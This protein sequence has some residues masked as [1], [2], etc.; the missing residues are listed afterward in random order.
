MAAETKAEKM[1]RE[2]D[3][4]DILADIPRFAREGVKSISE[5]DLLRLRWYGLYQQRPN[6]GH[7]MVRIKIPGGQLNPA[8]TRVIADLARRFGH[9]LSDIT[10]RQDIQLHWV[11]IENFPTIMAELDQ[12]G[13]Y[14]NEACGD[15][16]RNLVAC[17]LSGQMKDELFD[18]A[19]LPAIISRMYKDG[20][21]E[22]SN[23]PRK[24]KMSLSACPSHCTIPQIHCLS[25]FGVK[26]TK[27][28]REERG[29]GVC[30]GGG[31]RDTPHYAQSLRVFVPYEPH[32]SDHERVI[33]D[34]YR[35]V[36]HLFRDTDSLRQNRMRARLKFHVAEIGWEK[37]R[38]KL[39][40]NLGYKLEH[41]ESITAPV[42]A[43]LHD[44]LGVGELKNGLV[45]VGIPVPRGR[46]S[47]EVLH[48]LGDL[49]EK[50]G[51]D[52]KGLVR[53]TA[54]QNAILLNIPRQNLNELVQELT[55]I[56]LDPHAS[57]LRS[58]LIS[59]TGIQFCN[60]AITETKQRAA[61]I[62]AYLEHRLPP[63]EHVSIH[64][65]GCPN[66]CA[67]YQIADIGMSGLLMTWKGRPRQDAFSVMVGGQLGEKAA[68]GRV[69][70]H[71]DGKKLKLPSA[72]AHL[73]IEQL[74]L[75]YLAGRTSKA[76]TFGDFM[77]RHDMAAIH[78]WLTTPAMR[79][80]AA[81]VASVSG[82]EE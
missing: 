21:K 77:D 61:D 12:V 14:L 80:E 11:T 39:E 19:H 35:Q 53:L 41:D 54:K 2:K 20:G 55:Q 40:E 51:A 15:T 1:K 17:P 46:L 65:S 49:A 45:Y 82:K 48:T 37:F 30:V 78:N 32:N 24:F 43:T 23:L 25:L 26:R 71:P 44:H 76:E 5:D 64:I 33:L 79:D 16:P 58:S 31:L 28:G 52:R 3:G 38:D 74:I 56:G 4:L 69:V 8:Q 73:A 42:G 81:V 22:F 59:C 66:S 27:N 10:T 6:E 60:L 9:G 63:D 34:I 68:F 29:F 72:E 36:A 7:F 13:I 62:L 70:T 67:Q 47:A 50:Y 57:L 18:C 75:A